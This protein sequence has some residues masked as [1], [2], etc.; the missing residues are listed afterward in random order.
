MTDNR[1]LQSDLLLILVTLLA[2]AGWIFTKEALVGLTPLLF[3]GIRFLS[4][5]LLLGMLGI[6][7]LK[8]LPPAAWR[9]SLLTGAAMAVALS[10]W[11]MGLN[12]ASNLGIGA[13]ITSLGVVLTPVLG[14]LM[15][16]ARTRTST[17]VAVGIALLGLVMLRLEGGFL[18][19]L[20]D[21][22]FL[23]AALAFSVHFNL[24]S[25]FA[26]DIPALPLTAIQLGVTGLVAL[27]LFGLFEPAPQ[28][29]ALSIFGWLLASVLLG[30]CLRFFL[31]VKAQ[32][33]AQ[34]SHAA[35]IMTLEPV[36][37]ALLSSVWFSERMTPVQLTGCCL[38]FSALLV[39]RWRLL[40][41]RPDRRTV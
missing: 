19:S 9:R 35:V 27:L 20:S 8:R 2:A 14:R 39:S 38:I 36:W 29:S 12:L 7:S 5:G 33:M 25:R 4:A 18:L 26:A 31:Q 6:G 16:K 37:V 17:W 41:R 28:W 13:F 40:L 23:L 24:N 32:G 3:V 15:F 10:F 1:A 30:T 11:I 21:G 34:V 22:F